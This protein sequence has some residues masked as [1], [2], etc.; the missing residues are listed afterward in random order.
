MADWLHADDYLEH[1]QLLPMNGDKRIGH[2][3]GEGDVLKIAH[4]PKGFSAFCFRCGGKGFTPIER[5]KLSDFDIL[6]QK[7]A[8]AELYVKMELPNDFTQDI[9]TQHALWLYKAGIGVDR[10][11]ASGFGY[12]ER[13]GRVVL[14][15]Y[16]ERGNLVY[17]Q[18]RATQFPEQQPKYLNIKGAAKDDIIYASKP[19]N[20]VLTS[21]VIITEDILSAN[22]VGEVCDSYSIMGTKLSDGQTLKI[23]AYD[24][25]IWWLDGDDAGITGARKGSKSLQFHVRSQRI[26]RTPKD[27]KAYSKRWIR[28]ILTSDTY[29]IALW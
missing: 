28:S 3:C 17:I 19:D 27:P 24:H 4:T 22:R 6:K 11:H 14:P 25:A 2:W 29:D 26:I 9:P 21:T 10:I 12:S 7:E 5:Q 16:D 1:A 18:A 13:L 15:V 8:A 20:P 23:S